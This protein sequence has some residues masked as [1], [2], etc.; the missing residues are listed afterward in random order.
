MTLEL[1]SKSN[2]QHYTLIFWQCNIHIPHPCLPCSNSPH[3]CPPVIILHICVPHQC[4]PSVSSFVSLSLS[5]Y[6]C[7]PVSPSVW[8]CPPSMSP[9]LCDIVRHQCPRFCNPN[10]FFPHTCLSPISLTYLCPP[11]CVL[12]LAS[13]SMFPVFISIYVTPPI[14]VPVSSPL[15]K[16]LLTKWC[17]L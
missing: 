1:A 14:C 16:S 3:L 15:S 2:I 9:H 6:V 4:P 7:M 8:P 12:P 17:W 11:V 5:I 13:P 10:L